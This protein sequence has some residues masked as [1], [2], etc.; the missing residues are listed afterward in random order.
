MGVAYSTDDEPILSQNPSVGQGVLGYY[1]GGPLFFL[2]A[3]IYKE[4]KVPL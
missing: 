1:I 4:L 3:S 2:I